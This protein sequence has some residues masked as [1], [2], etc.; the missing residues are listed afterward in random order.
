M[1]TENATITF[2]DEPVEQRPAGLPARYTLESLLARGGQGAVYAGTDTITGAPIATKLLIAAD[3]SAVERVQREVAAMRVLDVPGVVRILD[4]GHDHHR[5]WIVMA[6]VPGAPFPAGRSDWPTLR[7]VVVAL[8][9]TLARVHDAGLL[10]RDIKPGNVLVDE[11]GRPVL[12]DFGLVRG[13]I[14]GPTITHVGAVM[15]TPRYM[16]PEQMRGDRA[17]RRTDLY[18]VGAMITEALTGQVPL[19][20][21]HIGA[22]FEARLRNDPPTLLSARPDLPTEVAAALD[23]LVARRPEARPTS[24]RAALAALRGEPAAH[25]LAWIGQRDGVDALVHT[26]SSGSSGAVLGPPGSGKSRTLREVAAELR[27]AGVPVHYLPPSDAPLGSLC[28]LLGD[29]PADDTDPM[30]TLQHRLAALLATGAVVLADDHER[31]DTWSR[32]VL[33]RTPGRIGIAVTDDGGSHD[34]LNIPIIASLRPFNAAEIAAMIEGPERL[35]HLPSDGAAV[36]LRRTGGLAARV[37]SEIQRWVDAELAQV[38]DG[39]LHIARAALDRV[40][41]GMAGPP[42]GGEGDDDLPPDLDELLAWVHLAGSQCTIPRLAAAR[43][44][45]AWR[46]TMRVQQLETHAAVAISNG[47][48]EPLRPADALLTWSNDARMAAHA[49]MA[50]A[51]PPG[52]SGRMYPLIALGN[53]TAAIDDACALAARLSADAQLPE[54]LAA[55]T[56]AGRLALSRSIDAPDLWKSLTILALQDGT[57]PA[58]AGAA[59]IT[60]RAQAEPSLCQL[61]DGAALLASGDPQRAAGIVRGIAPHTDPEVERLRWDLRLQVARGEG[62]QSLTETTEAADAWARD[63]PLETV[64]AARADWVSFR[65]YQEGAMREAADVARAGS[66]FNQPLTQRMRLMLRA[67]GCM[68][69]I[70][71]VNGVRELAGEM[72]SLARQRRLPRME[73]WA[74]WTLRLLDNQLRI[75]TGP[76]EELIHAVGAI[77]APDVAGLVWVNEA[78]IAWWTGNPTRGAELAARAEQALLGAGIAPNAVWA[79]A[80]HIACA[81]DP[82]AAAACAADAIATG[83]N[84]IIIEVLGVLKLSGGLPG[85]WSKEVQAAYDQARPIA[86]RHWR[87]GALSPDEVLAAFGLGV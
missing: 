44:E 84:D 51:M 33:T 8:L 69:I 65:M 64:Q 71:D 10:H 22:L 37:V 61:L 35:L 39:R 38:I 4:N 55:L 54:A 73:A 1:S 67:I 28:P 15:G 13:A 5:A 43:G 26:L 45:P 60:K 66:G 7:P 74:E 80:V 41:T 63:I 77:G 49:A 23:S 30:Q 42:L 53:A 82:D 34:T 29:P 79:R 78:V 52:T 2:S 36:M 70:A 57:R 83:R 25:A 20:T 18:A 75:A 24:A 62:T 14:T 19:E 87:R 9:E 81:P 86:Y 31:L 85:D 40:M 27:S 50:Q 76:D 58:L 16:A 56:E 47:I 21:E 11:A 48:I 17:D 32:A 68:L 72:R 6:H 59:E 12:L 3:Q 46:V